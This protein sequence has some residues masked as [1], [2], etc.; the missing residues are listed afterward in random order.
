ME[1]VARPDPISEE[2][3]EQLLLRIQGDLLT[4]TFQWH[5]TQVKGDFNQKTVL[6]SCICFVFF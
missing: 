6:M 5:H 4:W 2:D 1:A 3:L